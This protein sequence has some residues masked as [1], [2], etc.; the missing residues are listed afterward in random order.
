MDQAKKLSQYPLQRT[1]SH[2]TPFNIARLDDIQ[3]GTV[4]RRGNLAT[5]MIFGVSQTINTASYVYVKCM[6]EV[7]SLSQSVIDIFIGKWVAAVEPS[8]SD[9][10]L[11]LRC[12]ECTLGKVMTCI[13]P[14]NAKRQQWMTSSLV[15][16]WVRAHDTQGGTIAE[17]PEICGLFVM[18]SRLM[19]AEASKN[20]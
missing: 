10:M 15:L 17:I 16:I 5:H 18:A 19:Q 20:V 14:S 12:S 13:G 4:I 8:N 1:K 2:L 6:K 7:M 3:D 9:S 11:Q